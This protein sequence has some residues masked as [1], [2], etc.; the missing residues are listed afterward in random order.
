[1]KITLKK[2]CFRVSKWDNLK[3]YENKRCFISSFL[4]FLLC[5]ECLHCSISF[6]MKIFYLILKNETLWKD[7]SF[8]GRKTKGSWTK[9]Q[10][11][12]LVVSDNFITAIVDWHLVE[13]K[14]SWYKPNGT[15]VS[16]AKLILFYTSSQSHLLRIKYRFWHFNHQKC[17]VLTN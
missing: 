1:M 17:F 15:G 6:Q 9:L 5:F 3:I 12:R 13:F 14:I 2:C 11:F 16:K 7:I 8:D 4:L 10:K